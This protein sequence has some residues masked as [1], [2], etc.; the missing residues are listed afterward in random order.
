MR[1]LALRGENLASLTQAFEIDFSSGRLG[2]SGLFAITGNTGAGKSTLLDAICLA[3][4]DQMARFTPNRKFQPEIGRAEDADRL[5]ANDVR[6]ILSRGQAAG[7][8]EVDFR[9]SDG[10]LWRARWQL[11]RARNRTDGRYQKQERSLECLSAPELHAGNKRDL[12]ERIDQLVGLNWEQFRRAVILPQGDFAAFLKAGSDERSALLERMTG[13]A[14]YSELSVAAF[15]R[16]RD[17]K[18]ALA[19]LAAQLAELQPE[20][21]AG[22]SVLEQQLQ[23]LTS[24]LSEFKGW[25][26]AITQWQH[27]QQQGHELARHLHDARAAFEAEEARYQA[28]APDRLQLQQIERAQVA[29]PVFDEL[30][31]TQLE[32]QELEQSSGAALQRLETAQGSEQ[33]SQQQL[34]LL[35]Q[36]S[37][38]LEGEMRTLQPE[39]NEA[40]ELDALLQA[41]ERQWREQLPRQQELEAQRQRLGSQ[42]QAGQQQQQQRQREAT[43]L[44]QWLER[45][46]QG[47][48]A[49][50]Q[51]QPLLASLREAWQGQARLRT[52][53][54]QQHELQTLLQ[55]KQLLQQ[56]MNAGHVAAREEWQQLQQLQVQLEQECPPERLDEAQQ[57]LAHCQRRAE[58]GQ[59][60]RDLAEQASLLERQSQELR[61]R[62]EGLALREHELDSQLQQLAPELETL[63][64]QLVASTEAWQQAHVRQSLQQHRAQL[65]PEHP[66]PL[67]GSLDHP[68]QEQGPEVIELLARLGEQHRFLQQHLQQREQTWGQLQAHRQQLA[69]NAV[70][71]Q[72]QLVQCHQQRGQLAARWQQLSDGDSHW[73]AW[74]EQ[75]DGWL[76]VM[77]ELTLALQQTQQAWALAAE[78]W[79]RARAAQVR[80]QQLRQQVAAAQQQALTLERHLQE[81]LRQLTELQTQE[82]SLQQQMG[83]LQ[84]RLQMTAQLLDERLGDSQWRVWLER[85]DGEQAITLWQQECEFFLQQEEQW[86]RLR[87]QILQAEPELAAQQAQLQQLEREWQQLTVLRQ[88]LQ[89]QKADLQHRRESCL[90]GRQVADVERDWRLRHEQLRDLLAQ[91]Q[92]QLQTLAEQKA[93]AQ[94]ALEGLRQRQQQVQQQRREA[95]RSWLRHEQQLEIPEYE[96]HRLLSYSSDWIQQERQRLHALAAER[97]QARVR[98]AERQQA[99]AQHESQGQQQLAR[100]PAEA[101]TADGLVSSWVE[102]V[103]AQSQQLESQLFETRHRLKQGEERQAQ[104]QSLQQR[105]LEQQQSS[106]RWEQLGEL[107]GSASGAKFRSFA[108]GL[109][110]ERL[111]LEANAHLRELAPRYQLL[112]VPGS[113]LAL[114]VLDRDMGDEIRAVESLSG[115]ESFLVS[116]A[117]A[118]GLASLSGRETRIESLF[119]DEGFGTLDPESLDVAIACLDS[120]QAEGRQIGIISHV[121]A[122]VERI[123]VQVQ[124]EARGGGESRIRLPD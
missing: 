58:R 36:Q 109:T 62:H 22:Q 1:I 112:R 12:Q 79:D 72:H 29:R 90:G 35:E 81:L 76:A 101:H 54:R 117:L 18:Q 47:A 15:E 48:A 32:L 55:D 10:Q 115:G 114:Q 25:Q 95:L 57:Q 70:Q 103:Q 107:I 78:A 8:A 14:L 61:L 7:Y 50:R 108:Q 30:A 59:M 21:E 5:K 116:L 105:Y 43:E 75:P 38:Q 118:L 6:H 82:Q 27:W 87:Q 119:I 122:L 9:A 51:W 60:L 13:T 93:A 85:A 111:L 37:R 52:W 63:R 121:P 94:A 33:Q 31:R 89:M 69:D 24:Q 19:Q 123:G 80:L 91:Q 106:E 49:A 65:K 92:R 2:Q 16:A 68:W 20:G 66:C 77:A 39:L 44:G 17:E 53:R 98:L 88:N 100:L 83:H 74:P 124:V 73:P 102:Q 40:R 28:A 99:L 110:L 56:Q 67:C 97:E 96:L 46:Q 84:E 45:H 23:Q 26:Q 3:L 71:L 41:W 64:A 113:D 34:T 11:R 104:Y 42:V 4:Y 86:Q 120:L